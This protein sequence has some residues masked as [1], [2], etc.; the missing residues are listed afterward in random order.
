MFLAR[1]FLK[2]ILLE[3]ALRGHFRVQGDFYYCLTVTVI[4]KKY[5]VL[6]FLFF[7]FCDHDGGGVSRTPN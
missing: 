7:F 5:F 3:L 6:E 2:E 4:I 1:P